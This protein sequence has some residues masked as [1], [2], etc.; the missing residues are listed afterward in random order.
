MH[1][2]AMIWVLL[3]SLLGEPRPRGQSQLCEGVGLVTFV[4]M[5]SLEQVTHPKAGGGGCAAGVVVQGR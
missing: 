5:D 4:L 3:P 2:N 1:S